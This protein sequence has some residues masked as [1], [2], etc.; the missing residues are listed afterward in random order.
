MRGQISEEIESG[1]AFDD[2][3]IGT[4][5]RESAGKRWLHSLLS[6]SSRG[7]IAYGACAF[8]IPD[9][10][11]LWMSR[12]IEIPLRQ[13]PLR[14]LSHKKCSICP[15]ANKILIVQIFF[16]EDMNHSHGKRTVAPGP[17]P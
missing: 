5:E 3:S 12:R 10:E 16:L 8:F 6:V 1:A 13:K 7:V 15:L 14:V 4:G 11:G 2:F 17:D 9:E